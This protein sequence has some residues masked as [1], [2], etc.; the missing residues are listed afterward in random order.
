MRKG[1]GGVR[2]RCNA[3][4]HMKSV[5]YWGQGQ[6]TCRGTCHFSAAYLFVEQQKKIVRARK[7]RQLAFPVQDL[8]NERVGLHTVA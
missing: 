7:S 5:Q 1:A 8:Q 6:R 4:T 3:H 2:R